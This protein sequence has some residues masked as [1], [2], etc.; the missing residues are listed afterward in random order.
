VPNAP[1]SW[2]RRW[3]WRWSSPRRNLS[4][5]WFRTDIT[6]RSTLGEVKG[7]FKPVNTLG[8]CHN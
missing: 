5:S 4:F 7:F 1:F 2:Q 3:F 6:N 8:A